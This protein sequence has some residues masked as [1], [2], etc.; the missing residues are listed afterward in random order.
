MEILRFH[1]NF[2]RPHRALKFDT[3]TRTP[4]MQAG[5]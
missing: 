3:E 2:A 4:A 1:Y 5:S